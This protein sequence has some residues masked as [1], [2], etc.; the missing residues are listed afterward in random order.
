[1]IPIVNFEHMKNEYYFDYELKKMDTLSLY[2]Y[3]ITS[4]NQS[5]L[6]YNIRQLY[7]KVKKNGY[8]KK[9]NEAGIYGIILLWL[10]V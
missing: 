9:F 2:C 6:L 10:F 5:D 3:H 7:K 8:Y 4:K 1:M